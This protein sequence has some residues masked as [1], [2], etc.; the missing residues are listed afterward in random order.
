MP[1]SDK[2]GIKELYTQKKIVPKKYGNHLKNMGEYFSI[3]SSIQLGEKVI[4]H[5]VDE[6]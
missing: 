3:Q 4:Y 2:V 6:S 5:Y 1:R